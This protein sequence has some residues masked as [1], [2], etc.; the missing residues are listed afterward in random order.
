[1]A[2]KAKDW[3]DIETYKSLIQY[4]STALKFVLLANGGAAIALLSFLGNA[5][6]KYG[7]A[8]DMRWPMLCFV[9]GV[10]VGGLATITAYLTQFTL[11]NESQ[12]EAPNHKSR[13]HTLWLYLSLL[14]VTLGVAAFGIGALSAAWR[15][16]AKI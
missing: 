16:Y 13:S 14:L 7:M 10:L 15:L 8:V 6:A 11:Y 4:G 5:Y 1:M 12:R 2:D 9:G 3:H